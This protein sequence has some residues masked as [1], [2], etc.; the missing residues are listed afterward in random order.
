MRGRDSLLGFLHNLILF[1][2]LTLATS[3]TSEVCMESF[4]SSVPNGCD[5]PRFGALS[6]ET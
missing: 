5:L 2:G 4:V 3:T 6:R 1:F